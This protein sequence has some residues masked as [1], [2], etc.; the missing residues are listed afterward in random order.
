M[1]LV[2]KTRYSAALATTIIGKDL[3]MAS[4]IVKTCFSVE[5]G[6]LSPLKGQN[7][8]IGKAV[9]TEFG[10]FD[11]DSPFRKQGID[12]IVLGKAYPNSAG[13]SNRARFELHVGELNYALDI[14][15]LKHS[16]VYRS[17]LAW[18][19]IYIGVWG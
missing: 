18:F 17:H 2:N 7:W 11:E 4:L 13:P 1:D 6:K 12:V 3:M 15:R 5:H 14:Y 10:D 16:F 19:L 9:K 8:P